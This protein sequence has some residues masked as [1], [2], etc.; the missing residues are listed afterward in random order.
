MYAFQFGLL[1]HGLHY[2]Q[3]SG[4]TLRCCFVLFVSDFEDYLDVMLSLLRMVG[5]TMYNLKHLR[6]VMFH[7]NQARSEALRVA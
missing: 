7:P 4:D 5:P 3:E 6:V 1:H 2:D